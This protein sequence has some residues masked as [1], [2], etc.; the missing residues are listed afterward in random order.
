MMEES[1]LRSV[2]LPF[3]DQGTELHI[4]ETSSAFEIKM[5]ASGEERKYFY[6]K[7]TG[8]IEDRINDRKFPSLDVLLVSDSFADLTKMASSQKRVLAD[9]CLEMPLLPTVSIEPAR[10]DVK[11]SKDFSEFIRDLIEPTK[12]S[13]KIKILLLD[14]PAGIGKTY[15][16]ERLAFE[17]AQKY[18]NGEKYPPIL[19][20]SSRGR[21]LSRLDDVIAATIQ[22]FRSEGK[23]YYQQVPIL[24]RQRLLY[25][26]LDGFDELVD[27]DGYKNAW[28][29]LS[30]F[31]KQIGHSGVCIL[32]GRDTFFDQKEFLKR[33][34]ASEE[35]LEVIQIHFSEVSQGEASQW[36]LAKHFGN[37][38]EVARMLELEPYF[39]RPY[40]LTELSKLDHDT[41]QHI[42]EFSAKNFLIQKFIERESKLIGDALYSEFQNENSIVL[43]TRDLM[44]EIAIDMS[45][46]ES[47]YV[48]SEF[49]SFACEV[50]FEGTDESQIKRLQHRIK[51][52]AFLEKP[53]YSENDRRFPHEA[54]QYYFASIGIINRVIEGH[55]P[56]FLR[57][58]VIGSDFLENFVDVFIEEDNVSDKNVEKFIAILN[59]R[60]QTESS[61]DRFSQNTVSLL[62]ATLLRESFSLDNPLVLENL[63]ANEVYLDG[64]SSEDRTRAKLNDVS[65]NRLTAENADLRDIDFT[66][67]CTISI[68]IANNMTQFGHTLPH[69]GLIYFKDRHGRSSKIHDP[70]QIED[71]LKSHSLIKEENVDIDY[72]ESKVY[73]IFDKVCRLSQKSSLYPK[74]DKTAQKI[75]NSSE[76][77]NIEPIL[78]KY[79]FL[80]EERTA[81]VLKFR[82]KRPS[83]LLNPD[84]GSVEEEVMEEIKTIANAER[85]R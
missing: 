83:L 32:A 81:E 39:L 5:F 43:K 30:N 69:V 13:K 85:S 56:I 12:E 27:S 4:R 18:L 67:D 40:F 25:L 48:D 55:V 29:L 63:Y 58:G 37:R 45:E 62:F 31:L 68:F 17:H 51:T 54:I 35:I 57:R 14:G 10:N 16:I 79:E 82:V 6:H 78:K 53:D 80:E 64:M 7:Q 23:F 59:S 20:A 38:E 50:V 21:R 1:E 47:I 46:R 73:K 3:S 8:K 24:T 76:W 60:L 34:N 15:F 9:K 33:L 74:K 65:I 52:L 71:W 11:L 66:S 19:H 28:D 75:Y 2:L 26:A 61:N 36:L 49:L 77:K 44:T 70:S 72:K 84:H 41:Y 22:D 42:R